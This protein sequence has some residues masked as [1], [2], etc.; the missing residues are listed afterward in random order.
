MFKNFNINYNINKPIQRNINSDLVNIKDE[1]YNS[2]FKTTI[3]SNTKNTESNA[4]NFCDT[5]KVH[6]SNW[7]NLIKEDITPRKRNSAQRIL[8]INN[9][10]ENIEK[11]KNKTPKDTLLHKDIFFKTLNKIRNISVI[12]KK[13]KINNSEKNKENKVIYYNSSIEDFYRNKK[14]ELESPLNYKMKS[15]SPFP[16]SS[17]VNF[18]NNILNLYKIKNK[19]KKI[20]KISMRLKLNKNINKPNEVEEFSSKVLKGFNFFAGNKAALRVL[21]KKKPIKIRN[22]LNPIINSYGNILDELSGKIGFMKDSINLIY[23]KISQAKYLI[24]GNKK[25]DEF[26]GSSISLNGNNNPNINEGKI[27]TKLILYKINKRKVNQTI[28]S[29]YPIYLTNKAKNETI[30]HAKIYS[31]R[32]KKINM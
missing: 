8:K 22:S 25:E 6:Q 1:Y 18:V 29:K 13:R 19:D 24:N 32:H 27:N 17:K 14:K 20:G 9:I 5:L 4:F 15:L 28:S 11:G 31:L 12:I 23:P 26:N 16:R 21:F 2:N 7:K 3:N 30:P 10:K